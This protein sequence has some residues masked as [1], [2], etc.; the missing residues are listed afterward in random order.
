MGGEN[1]QIERLNEDVNKIKLEVGLVKNK[2][3]HLEETMQEVKELLK[4]QNKKVPMW[5]VIVMAVPVTLIAIFLLLMAILLY[6]KY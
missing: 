2:L 4:D 6:T 3:E 1:A 5:V